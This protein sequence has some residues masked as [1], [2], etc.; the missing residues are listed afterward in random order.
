MYEK[1]SLYSSFSC[2]SHVSL[3]TVITSSSCL[4]SFLPSNLGLA[5]LRNAF[6]RN[7]RNLLHFSVYPSL[8]LSVAFARPD[9][10]PE[11]IS[12]HVFWGS[13]MV[14]WIIIAVITVFI[15]Q[16][17]NIYSSNMY[18]CVSVR[19]VI[20]MECDGIMKRSFPPPLPLFLNTAIWTWDSKTP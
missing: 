19:G 2:F 1:L 8:S 10:K 6:P 17:V 11:I 12:S 3:I 16:Y 9:C 4:P 13:I 7:W 15:S 20:E 18:K 14:I 5:A